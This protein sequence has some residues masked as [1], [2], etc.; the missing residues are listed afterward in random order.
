[1]IRVVTF[2][3]FG[4][5]APVVMG[6]GKNAVAM[7]IPMFVRDPCP[8]LTPL[9]LVHPETDSFGPPVDVRG[10]YF[11]PQIKSRSI[12]VGADGSMGGKD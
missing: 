3:Y 6:R 10:F 2:R 4:M 7:S 11:G 9:F 8:H 5:H 12:N 1:M